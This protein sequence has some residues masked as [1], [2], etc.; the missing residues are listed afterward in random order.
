MDTAKEEFLCK[1]FVVVLI[2][3][4]WLYIPLIDSR[5]GTGISLYN[6]NPESGDFGRLKT[7]VVV[8]RNLYG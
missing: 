1:V 5:R 7:T 6:D 3:Q 2:Y 4:G 8:G